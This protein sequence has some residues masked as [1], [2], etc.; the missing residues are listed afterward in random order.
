MNAPTPLQRAAALLRP[1]GSKGSPPELSDGSGALHC[2]ATG[3]EISLRDGVLDLLEDRFEPT[4]G[5]R[6]LDN[7][8]TAWLYDLVRPH[9]GP[10][11]GMPRFASEVENLVERLHLAPG[12]TVLDIACGQGNFT[13]ELARRV[14]P[15]GLV[16]GL[17]IAGAMLQRAV[18]RVR[19]CGLD[20][21]LLV[22]A[23][24]LELPFADA[25]LSRINCSG[26]IHQFPDLPRAIDEMAR[27]SASGAR[28]TLSGFAS[29]SED[30]RVGFK[31]WAERFDVHFV[32]MDE[33][34]NSLEVAGFEEVGGGMVGG[35]VGYRWARRR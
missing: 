21:V 18:Q 13:V 5:Q 11:L 28:L 8:P 20:N 23:D 9:L 16:I 6:L 19:R 3:R 27:V 7:A 34:A 35:W 30:A 12:D 26:G 4:V 22:R 14:G 25:C 32:P 24:A 1:D 15:R 10:L 2:S 33:L 17:D 29:A 31:R